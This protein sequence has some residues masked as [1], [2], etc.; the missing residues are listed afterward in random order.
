[1]FNL[2]KHYENRQRKKAIDDP[3]VRQGDPAPWKCLS[4][5]QR[6]TINEWYMEHLIDCARR[7]EAGETEQ[8]SS[9]IWAAVIG[10]IPLAFFHAAQHSMNLPIVNFF[11]HFV[12]TLAAFLITF[13]FFSDVYRSVRRSKLSMD[14]FEYVW[15]HLVAVFSALFVTM[16]TLA[17]VTL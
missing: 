4:D 1:M 8:S 10:L 2:I 12:V 6:D 11:L 7:D 17:Y 14:R 15:F 5:E 13:V 9:N 16:V 3:S